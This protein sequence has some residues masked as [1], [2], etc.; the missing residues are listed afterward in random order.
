[1]MSI[2]K[3]IKVGII[4]LDYHL[5]CLQSSIYLFAKSDVELHV[6]TKK[7]FFD[8]LSPI[9]S[10]INVKWHIPIKDNPKAVRNFLVKQKL[11]LESMDLV[12][13]NTLES[14]FKFFVKFKLSTII[15][16]RIHNAYTFLNPLGNVEW[17]TN[18][19][20]FYKFIS[21]IFREEILKQR[22]YWAARFFSEVNYLMFPNI[23]I[24]KYVYSNILNTVEYR[25]LSPLPMAYPKNINTKPKYQSNKELTIV[26]PGSVDPKRR[27]YIEIHEAF[28]ILRTKSEKKIKVIFLGRS[29]LYVA[30]KIKRTFM[31]ICSEKLEVVFFDK[32][33]PMVEYENYMYSCDVM[34]NPIKIETNY[35]IFKEIYGKTKISGAV[36]D[37]V[38]YG[39]PL[40]LPQAYNVDMDMKNC[41][42]TYTN[43][44]NLVD[45]I[46]NLT[47][48]KYL[49]NLNESVDSY[50]SK[51]NK[52]DYI[53]TLLNETSLN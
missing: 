40:I 32:R 20:S 17:P 11:L 41:C 23:N 6:F 10:N 18:I 14:N 7:I 53:G 51:I 39:R 9:C 35:H 34:L 30:S 49:N 43:I 4:E 31:R 13:F 21:Y 8:E 36:T 52:N 19:F 48:N 37:I 16:L 5:E 24:S 12:L 26:I 25:L 3:G 45:I 1:M 22:T 42:I 44:D 50:L 2:N 33:I 47:N 28:K 46:L 38:R 15:A 27:N 29:N